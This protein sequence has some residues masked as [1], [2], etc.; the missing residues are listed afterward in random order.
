SPFRL[1]PNP[2]PTLPLRQRWLRYPIPSA[3]AQVQPA[4]STRSC[5][6]RLMRPSQ[7]L[8]PQEPRIRLPISEPHPATRCGHSLRWRELRPQIPPGRSRC[9]LE[10]QYKMPTWTSPVVS[11]LRVTRLG[12]PQVR[13]F[14]SLLFGGTAC[15]RGLGSFS[16]LAFRLFGFFRLIR[17]C[18][19]GVA[20]FGAT[21]TGARIVGYIPP[22]PLELHR[23]RGKKLR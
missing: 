3:Q 22:C 12:G 11:K 17:L 6:L 1:W 4:P 10:A 13:P 20:G 18:A 8:P 19:I 23:R 16:R 2:T 21:S 5:Y 7:R 15:R 9:R 14:S